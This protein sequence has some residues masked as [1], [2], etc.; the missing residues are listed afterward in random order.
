[1]PTTPR[2]SSFAIRVTSIA[3][4]RTAKPLNSPPVTSSAPANPEAIPARPTTSVAT[5]TG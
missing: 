4:I 1:M 5:T 2:R 3:A